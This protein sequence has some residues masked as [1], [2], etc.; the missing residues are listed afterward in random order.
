VIPILSTA[1]MREADA[2]EVARRGTEAL[3]RAAGT[4][5]GLEAKRLLGRVYGARVAVVAGPGLNG[6]DGRVAAAWL[7]SR[8]AKVVVIEVASQPAT[9]AGYDLV[10]DAAFGLGSSRA[11][12]APAVAGRALVLAVDLPSGVNADSGEVFGAAMAADVTLA[13]GALKPAHL[14][15]PSATLAGEVRFA[16]LGIVHDFVDGLMEDADLTSLGDVARDDH[17]WVHAVQILAGSPLMPGAAELVARGAMAG[18]ASMIRLTSRGDLSG[19][20]RLPAEVVH[21]GDEAIDR[22]CRAVVAGPGLG[23]DAPSWLRERLEG[24]DVTVV[25]DADALDR[26]VL[27]RDRT[28]QQRWILTPH[29]GEFARLTGAAVP[30]NRFE[31]VRALAQET[32]CV[33][34]LKGPTTVIADPD[35]V[36]RVVTSG[37]PA[38]ATAGSGDVLSGLIGATVARGHRP[39]EATALAAHVHGRASSRLD[40][41]AGASALV[42]AVASVLRE[43]R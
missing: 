3:V 7:A 12:D 26:A 25:L 8:G 37:T 38:L 2:L 43:R 24:V 23:S 4:A 29:D 22:R 34:L 40:P 42:G 32:G 9:L 36:L 33:V 18:G 11:Y 27:P 5:V 31:A 39:L 15:G 21:V 1:Q 14:T 30:A 20:V 19:R 6:A 17:K 41:Y 16:G 28:T 13:L 10:I 35:G